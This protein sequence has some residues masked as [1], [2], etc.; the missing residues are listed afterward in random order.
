MKAPASTGS[1]TPVRYLP[2]PEA[3]NSTASLMSTGSAQ[4][5]GGA[6]STWVGRMLFTLMEY[7]HER[8]REPSHEPDDAAL[9]GGV[10][11]HAVLVRHE[12]RGRNWPG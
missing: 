1:V 3:R 7:G 2:S 10:V 8:Q 6:V 12:A 5:T 11:Q 4:G 9:A